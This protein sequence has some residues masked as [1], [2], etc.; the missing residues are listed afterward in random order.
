[1]DHV[2]HLLTLFPDVSLFHQGLQEHHIT[3]RGTLQNNPLSYKKKKKIQQLNYQI[4]YTIT[5]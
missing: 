5:K 4:M 2:L 1:M 3:V